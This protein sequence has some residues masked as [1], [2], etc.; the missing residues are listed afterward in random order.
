MRLLLDKVGVDPNSQHG[1]EQHAALHSAAK[2][3]T[4]LP[5]VYTVAFLTCCD[6]QIRL[7]LN[8]QQAV[9]I[10]VCRLVDRHNSIFQVVLSP[11][12]ICATEPCKKRKKCADSHTRQ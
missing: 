6:G 8:P 5:A 12:H 4:G 11:E 7:R 2:S 10:H 3:G 9:L 1:R